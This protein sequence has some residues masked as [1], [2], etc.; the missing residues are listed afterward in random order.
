M[1]RA[2]SASKVPE[3]GSPRPMWLKPP[4]RSRQPKLT[5][6]QIIAGAA[7]RRGEEA[8]ASGNSAPA[9]R[10]AQ[11]PADAATGEGQA[12]G[13]G[14][15]RRRRRGRRG[16]GAGATG[17]SDSSSEAPAPEG[18]AA[19][20][21]PA[22][23]HASRAEVAA[24]LDVGERPAGR[25]R[26]GRRGGRSTGAQAAPAETAEAES[27]PAPVEA[28]APPSD[29]AKPR[30]RAPRARTRSRARVGATTSPVV[31]PDPAGA[32]APAAP[33]AEPA[34]ARRPMRRRAGAGQAS[35]TPSAPEPVPGP[36]HRIV[37]LLHHVAEPLRHERA[38][39]A[40]HHARHLRGPRVPGAGEPLPPG[41]VRVIYRDGRELTPCDRKKAEQ[42]VALG[43]A[44][45]IG[46]RT[47]R[48]RYDPFRA[49]RTRRRILERDQGVCAYCGAPGDT[50]DHLT[51]WS[52]GGRTTMDNCVTSCAECNFRRGN[53]PVLDFVA[54][55]GIAM[56]AMRNPVLLDYVR[57]AHAVREDERAKS[58]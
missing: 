17:T 22:G 12:P 57:A 42:E 54:A 51:P 13:A 46:E 3:E 36:R 32:E 23:A 19:K 41:K 6:D 30:Q 24:T 9:P 50:I 21:E 34:P 8:P 37:P 44:K 47:I 5:W 33:A 14:R 11:T 48:L 56:R 29:D 45:W 4:P 15:R 7:G 38:A 58:S 53:R 55:E 18:S 26:R 25:R 16:H 1:P 28:E 43:R 39:D 52:L 35:Q 40:P 31:A 10:P 27:P 49:R 20:A 2:T